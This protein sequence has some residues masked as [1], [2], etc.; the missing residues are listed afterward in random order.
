[1]GSILE[2]LICDQVYQVMITKRDQLHKLQMSK[3]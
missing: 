2:I 3:I 1:M